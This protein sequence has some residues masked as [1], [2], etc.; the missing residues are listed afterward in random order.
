MAIAFSCPSCDRTY[1]VDDK[2]AGKV[3]TCKTCSTRMLV[4]DADEDPEP[5]PPPRPRAQV[6]T[7]SPP[8]RREPPRRDPTPREQADA[9]ETPKSPGRSAAEDASYYAKKAARKQRR[10]ER[11]AEIREERG[12]SLAVSRTV[13]SGI[14]MMGIA[15][16]C[17]AIGL[18]NNVFI[19]ITPFLFLFGLVTLV[20]GLMGRED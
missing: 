20:K 8:P 10:K 12:N 16:I 4:P 15:V 1:S 19:Y 13:V 6:L 2:F 11:D 17:C 7:A 5:D 14:T 9:Q 3:V 18:M